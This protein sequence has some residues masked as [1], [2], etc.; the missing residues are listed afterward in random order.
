MCGT[1]NGENII[2]HVAGIDDFE[3]AMGDYRV[4]LTR[5]PNARV[6]LRQGARTVRT[7][8][9]DR[10]LRKS[11]AHEGL[12]QTSHLNGRGLTK[13]GRYSPR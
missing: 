12:G 11:E 4:A 3:V 9:R 13:R 7:V 1:A 8:A 2:E 6:I 10:S 5:W